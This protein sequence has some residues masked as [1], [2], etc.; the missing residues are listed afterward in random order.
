MKVQIDSMKIF[1]END[2]PLPAAL[3][4]LNVSLED[5]ILIRR[6]ILVDEDGER[7][8]IPPHGRRAGDCPVL[9]RRAGTL[10][11]Q[12]SAAGIAAYDAMRGGKD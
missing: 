7:R 11:Q 2:R 1:S 4:C 9:W 5:Q 12:I 8:V 3:A 6:C 10:A